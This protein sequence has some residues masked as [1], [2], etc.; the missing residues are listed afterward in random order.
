MTSPHEY[1]RFI[2][3]TNKRLSR[4]LRRL[5]AVQDIEAGNPSGEVSRSRITHRPFRE[6]E[7][8]CFLCGGDDAVLPELP[9]LDGYG[10][11]PSFRVHGASIAQGKDA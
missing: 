6:Q 10:L 1:P 7:P 8:R 9:G 4:V 11:G 3:S 5:H 2:G